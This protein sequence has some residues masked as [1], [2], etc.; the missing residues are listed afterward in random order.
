M[1]I[2]SIWP[3]DR[4]LSG[5][6]LR[7][8]VNVG[9]MPM[10]RYSALPITPTFNIRLRSLVGWGSYPSAEKQSVYSTS[11]ADKADHYLSFRAKCGLHSSPINGKS[12]EFSMCLL[13]NLFDLNSAKVWTV[14]INPRFFHPPFYLF[15]R[16]KVSSLNSLITFPTHSNL[17]YNLLCANSSL[18]KFP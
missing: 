10:K 8:K 2:S 5:A 4:T 7:A 15:I 14:L 13:S 12:P 3:R 6:K 9:E 18:E 1:S 11:P 16:L 17:L